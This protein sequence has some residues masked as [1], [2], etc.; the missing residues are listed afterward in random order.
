MGDARI[1]PTPIPRRRQS[2]SAGSGRIRAGEPGR[3]T[4][5][6]A[7]GRSHLRSRRTGPGSHQALVQKHEISRSD[8]DGARRKPLRLPRQLKA[9][10]AAIVSREQKIAERAAWSSSG[11]RKSKPPHRPQQVTDRAPSR[12]RRGHMSKLAPIYQQRSSISLQRR[13]TL[14]Q[15]RDGRKTV[16]LGHA[17][18]GTGC[19]SLFH[20]TT[21][22]SRELQRDGN[23]NG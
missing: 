13:S 9:D 16:E 4:A 5:Q 23:S 12:N 21:S 18:A 19:S 22:G 6:I 2:E 20:W 17:S 11:R 15:R 10:R 3:G 8:Y 7:A 14:R 1:R